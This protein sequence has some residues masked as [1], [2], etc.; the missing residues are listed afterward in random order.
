MRKSR[1]NLMGALIAVGAL[2]ATAGMFAWRWSQRHRAQRSTYHR[3]L[4]RWEGEGGSVEP[5]PGNPVDTAE[6]VAAAAS[7]GSPA[8]VMSAASAN[9]ASTVAN[10]AAGTPWPF[11]HGSA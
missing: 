3:E 4:S 11:P 6:A 2:G 1:T 5:N 7:G 10:G 8:G 9:A